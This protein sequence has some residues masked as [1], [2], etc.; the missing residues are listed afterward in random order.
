MLSNVR[1]DY[2]MDV[3]VESAHRQKEVAAMI[4][5]NRIKELREAVGL[6]QHKFAAAIGISYASAQRY[7]YGQRDIPGD[8]LLRMVALFNVS[9]DYILGVSDERA[10]PTKLT[11]G[12]AESFLVRVRDNNMTEDEAALIGLFRSMDARGREQLMVFAKGCAA[13]YPKNKADS[14]GA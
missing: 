9:S 13:S 7:E 2:Y 11:E 10:K 8:V 4:Q 14:L 12:G 6:S 5:A 1:F 3:A